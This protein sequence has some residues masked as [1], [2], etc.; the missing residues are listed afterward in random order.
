MLK[1]KATLM[2][3]KDLTESKAKKDT[4]SDDSGTGSSTGNG[5]SSNTGGSTNTRGNGGNG[6]Y[7]S[8]ED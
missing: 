8:Y 3:I 1:Q 5:G 4:D 2:N 7:I 6:D